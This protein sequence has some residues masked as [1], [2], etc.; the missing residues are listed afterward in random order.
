MP[1]DSKPFDLATDLVKQLITLSTGILTIIIAFGKDIFAQ[2]AMLH[3]GWLFAGLALH[4]LSIMAGLAAYMALIG[5]L[6]NSPKP[7][8]Y[9]KNVRAILVVQILLFVGGVVLTFAY[10]FKLVQ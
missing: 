1:D 8:I 4:L 2:R 6:A 10:A 9:A 5:N 3:G 7:S